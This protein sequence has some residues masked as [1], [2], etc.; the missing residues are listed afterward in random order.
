[1]IDRPN[2][3]LKLCALSQHFRGGWNCRTKRIGP[4]PLAR[5]P[6]GTYQPYGGTKAKQA[7]LSGTKRIQHP[8]S[9]ACVG[10]QE[11]AQFH[12]DPLDPCLI[13]LDFRHPVGFLATG[14]I[15]H[16]VPAAI[17][18]RTTDLLIVT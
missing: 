10:V 9:S 18:V 2:N 7:L 1:M 12:L 15:E 6:R 5:C 16:Q 11:P 4:I 3:L 8:L 17:L 14:T 13:Q